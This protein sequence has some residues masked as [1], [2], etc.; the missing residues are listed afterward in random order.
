[1]TR[2]V[3]HSYPRYNANTDNISPSGLVTTSSFELGDRWKWY[4]FIQ[5]EST[6]SFFTHK[7]GPWEELSC[8]QLSTHHTW[9][10]YHLKINSS[11]QQISWA[12][13][14]SRPYWWY[15]EWSNWTSS[16]WNSYC[17]YIVRKNVLDGIEYESKKNLKMEARAIESFS[18]DTERK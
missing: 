7:E 10:S 17:Y 9:A 18:I 1:M 6:H 12:T 5:R 4:W 8:Y 3:Y 11:I 15:E 14:P 16:D 2:Y 13:L